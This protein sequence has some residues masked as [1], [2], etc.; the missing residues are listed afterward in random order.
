MTVEP[1][2]LGRDT[3][4]CSTRSSSSGSEGAIFF[5]TE[6]TEPFAFE[7]TPSRSPT[8]LHPGAERVILFHIVARGTCWVAGDDGERHWA[9][10]GDV[11]VLPVRRPPRD[12]RRRHRRRA[13]RSPT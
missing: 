12:R 8:L 1:P 5:R 10:P 9:E 7:S 2:D 3:R 4:C 11:I 13:S 6:L